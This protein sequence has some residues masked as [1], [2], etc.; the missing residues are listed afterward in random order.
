M[1][2][3]ESRGYSSRGETRRQLAGGCGSLM[4]L[5]SGSWPRLST[6]SCIKPCRISLSIWNKHNDEV[7]GK[8]LS[9]IV[10]KTAISRV[11]F[12]PFRCLHTRGIAFIDCARH[13]A[14]F[15]RISRRDENSNRSLAAESFISKLYQI[16]QKFVFM[17]IFLSN[18]KLILKV[19]LDLLS[20]SLKKMRV[21]LTREIGLLEN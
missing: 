15:L 16:A 5:P 13:A 19:H 17:T 2:L 3:A 12:P 6:P 18:K 7:V 9:G 8:C 1:V 14:R 11:R 10:I 20:V 4:Y 21:I